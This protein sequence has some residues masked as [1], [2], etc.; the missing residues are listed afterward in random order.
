[1]NLK[2]CTKCGKEFSSK[3][4]DAKFCSALCRQHEVRGVTDNGKSVT[5]NNVEL[6]IKKSFN[7]Q[8]CT[9]HT[10]SMKGTCGCK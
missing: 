5:D 10:Y 1:M 7:T 3:R 2:N 9:K 6:P 8:P 4:K